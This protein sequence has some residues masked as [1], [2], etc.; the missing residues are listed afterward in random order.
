LTNDYVNFAAD[1]GKKIILARCNKEKDSTKPGLV[2]RAVDFPTLML[3]IG[4]SPAF[5]FY[6]SK[7]EDYDSLIKFYKYL[8]NEEQ[9]TQPICK[10]LE[11]KEG[12]GY[13][14]YVAILL[15]VL[16]KIGKPI[17]IDENSSSN[18]S[19]LINLSTL[20]D[21]KDEWRILPYLSELKKVLEALPL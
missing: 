9:D 20:V 11:R 15:L 2:R 16:E 10:E 4:F 18:Y 21:L 8:L 17:K 13:A 12:A 3:S 6:L 5:T 14:G 19:L 7:I 1:V